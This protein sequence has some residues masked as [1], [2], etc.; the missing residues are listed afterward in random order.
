M[1]VSE[2]I[3][4]VLTLLALTVYHA[5]AQSVSTGK[6]ASAMPTYIGELTTN[7][8]TGYGE[9]RALPADELDTTPAVIGTT[10]LTD[11]WSTGTLYFTL[12]RLLETEEFKYDL[13]NNQFLIKT[14][15]TPEPTLDQLRVIY[16]N[17]V[18]AF[19]LHD[20]IR[21]KRIFINATNAG[22]T[23]EGQPVI[24]FLEVLVNDANMS[25]YRK[26]DTELLRSS[27]NVALNSGEKSDRIIKKEKYYLKQ[28]DQKE[29]G[30][31]GKRKKQNLEHFS[32]NKAAVEDFVKKNNTD[33]TSQA[34][35]VNL[36][37]YYN[38]L[39]Q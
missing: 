37:N 39:T 24:G 11:N 31:V 38:T 8:G 3:A 25:L 35:L 14:V 18:D 4:A 30:E 22:L 12:N 23:N 28:S 6:S 16:S 17:T 32:A 21:G 13:E 19:V 7:V 26:I 29:L 5:D 15:N 34:S 27:Y 2:K 33:F 20:P 10:F 9:Y 1:K 36:V